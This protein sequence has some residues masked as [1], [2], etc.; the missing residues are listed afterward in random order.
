VFA[1]FSQQETTDTAAN[2]ILELASGDRQAREYVVLRLPA[3][4]RGRPSDRVWL[5]AV[6]LAGA[7]QVAEAVPALTQALSRGA[8][9]ASVF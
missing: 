9:P 5:N 1:E 4:I 6:R 8:I 3:M 7:L 2:D